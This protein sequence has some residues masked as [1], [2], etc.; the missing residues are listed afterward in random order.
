MPVPETTVMA[1]V[2]KWREEA[3]EWAKADPG[4]SVT[5]LVRNQETAATLRQ[6]ARELEQ[7]M[8]NE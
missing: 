4:D 7:A 8:R 3:D 2:A 5:T 6:C 1:L